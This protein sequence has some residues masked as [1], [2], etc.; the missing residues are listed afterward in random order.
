MKKLHQLLAVTGFASAL[1]LSA[2][3]LTAQDPPPPGGGQGGDRGGRGGRGGPG[4][5][6]DPVQMQQWFLEQAKQ[7]LE[8]TDE[9]EWKAL[10]PMVQKVMDARRE[11]MVGGIGGMMRGMGRGPRG[12]DAAGGGGGDQ[13]NRRPSFF[14]E[15]SPEAAA[16]EKAIESKASKEEL[17]AAMAKVRAA[18]KEKEAKL[19]DAQE[20]LRKV[21]TLRQEAIAVSSGW[22]D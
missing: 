22:L 2:S 4:G 5:G 6:F 9:T 17:K 13:Q 8:V 1:L 19:K 10:E 21:L 7:K 18:K 14:G 11:A 12:G 15:P 20:S 3:N 16:L